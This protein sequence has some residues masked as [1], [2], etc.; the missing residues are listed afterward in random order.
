MSCQYLYAAKGDKLYR[1]APPRS[2]DDHWL[3]STKVIESGRNWNN[4]SHLFFH[5]DGTLYSVW[6]GNFYKGSSP[7]PDRL[8][9]NGGWNFFKLLF[10]DP[11]GVLYAV[12]DDELFK[13]APPTGVQDVWM[14]SASCVGAGW[15]NF[16]FLF[17][18]PEGILHGVENGKF[19]KYDKGLAS[20]TLIGNAGWSDFDHLFFMADGEL[21]GVHQD[22]FYKGLPPSHSNEA[23]LGSATL[24][25]SNGWSEFRFV[26]SP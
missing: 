9:G 16:K 8:I 12:N 21:Y 14:A 25:G 10:F 19:R 6:G 15:S 18:D 23:W 17:F 24:I 7:S 5:P 2:S 13:G 22:K 3:G 4:C 11:N 20:S 26:M 1:G